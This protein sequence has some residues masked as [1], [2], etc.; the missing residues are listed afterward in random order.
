M[1]K[2]RSARGAG[3]KGTGSNGTQ[4]ALPAFAGGQGATGISRRALVAGAGGLAA[5][6]GLAPGGALAQSPFFAGQRIE[7]LSGNSEGS[8]A[9]SQM[10]AF[11]TAIERLYPGTLVVVRANTGGTSALTAAI[12][13]EAGPDGLT[14][15][16][17]DIDSL[18][19]RT[20][21]P[22]LHDITEFTVIG[23][24]RRSS[25]LLFASTLSG[26]ESVDDLIERAEP[27]L[28]AVR[29]TASSGYLTA[30]FC[31][32]M[33]GTRI[34]PVTG[35]GSSERNLAFLNGEAD[36]I[37]RTPDF[38][39]QFIE[40]GTARAILKFDDL[41]IPDLYGD[42]PALSD[43]AYD[44]AYRWIAE[45]FRAS[46]YSRILV[47][48]PGVP[49]DRVEALRDVFMQVMADPDFGAAVEGDLTITPTRG[50]VLQAA[51]ASMIAELGDLADLGERVDA[52]LACG[53][54]VGET[55]E[56]CPAPG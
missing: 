4:A 45:Y 19:Q 1:F 17:S 49:T 29:S 46:A 27:A 12:L 42:P 13:A 3:S 24:M 50:E 51:L 23:S 53:L 16:T 11:A 54:H 10:Q 32:A 8:V 7:I 30:L 39:V 31:N 36:L 5:S 41:E 2:G 14:L 26:I 43:L 48:P 35:Y 47:V 22:G 38:G 33:L 55:G 15:G 52:T 34:R 6:A 20:S 37:F 21:Q 18:L 40:E 9:N 28:L 44:R 25:S 56:A